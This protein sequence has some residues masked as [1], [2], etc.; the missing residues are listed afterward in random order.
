MKQKNEKTT[1]LFVNKNAQALKPVQVSSSLI[2]NWKKYVA[3]LLIIFLCLAGAIVYLVL[4]NNKEKMTTQILSQKI[5]SLH[6]VFKEVDTSQVRTKFMKI[7]KQLS[8]I[9]GFLKARGIQPAF[10]KGIGG[11]ADSDVLSADEIT[12]FYE[13]YLGRVA[14]NISYTP[15]G[16]PF[17]GTITSTF[18]HRENPF[19]GENVET[20]KGL[21][22]S[23][24]F[25]ASV[26]AMAKGEVEFAGV[27]GGFGNCIILKHAN[28]FETLYGHLSKILVKAGD[29]INIGQEIGK[30]GS[31]GRSTGPHLHYE[32]HRNG[33]KINPQSFL[34]LN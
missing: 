4:M 13:K 8:A 3:G 22:I 1:I 17:H 5:H 20:H 9:N 34:T 16:L 30:I 31:T 29:Q 10:K 23:G 28:G 12:D 27:R 24:P 32:V 15:L 33:Q 19:G 7:D 11:E 25:G 2:L 18:G 26:K 14:Y 6:T 21:D